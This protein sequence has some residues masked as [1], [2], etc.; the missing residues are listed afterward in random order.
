MRR[1]HVTS[2]E[3]LSEQQSPASVSADELKRIP[4]LANQGFGNVG[5]WAAQLLWEAG[6][7]VVGISDVAGALVN[8]K[9]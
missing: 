9:V 3:Q 8:E 7:R 6:G 2:S 4:A 1:G 5:A